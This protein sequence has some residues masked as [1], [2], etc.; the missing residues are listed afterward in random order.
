MRLLMTCAALIAMGLTSAC[1]TTIGAGEA[2]AQYGTAR[3]SMPAETASLNDSWLR[4]VVE[5]DTRLTEVC[6]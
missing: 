1:V 3:A 4:W 6:R 5:T 2:C